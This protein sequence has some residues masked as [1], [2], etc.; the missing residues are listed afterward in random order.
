VLSNVQAVIGAHF[1][2]MYLFGSLASGGFN[3]HSSDIDFVVVTD[4]DLPNELLSRLRSMHADIAAS[5]LEWAREL[6]GFYIPRDYLRRYNPAQ[7]FPSIGVDWDFNVGGQDSAG[8]IMRHILREQG[9][10][11]AGPPLRERI[12]PVTAAQIRRLQPRY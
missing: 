5:G 8:V 12:D 6:E 7:R 10:V 2:G 1:H 4:S 11:L 9:I 3:P